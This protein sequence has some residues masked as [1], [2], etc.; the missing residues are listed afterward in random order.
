MVNQAYNDTLRSTKVS[1]GGMFSFARMKPLHAVVGIVTVF[2]LWSAV[3]MGWYVCGVNSL[4]SINAEATDAVAGE[5]S[6]VLG[7]ADTQAP[8]VAGYDRAG[9]A[10]EI[11]VMLMIAFTLG[12]L[13]GR[14]LGIAGSAQM[15]SMLETKIAPLHER[16]SAPV[17]I[18]ELTKHAPRP[19]MQANPRLPVSTLTP[20]PIIHLPSA[21]SRPPIIQ[22][23]P[24]AKPALETPAQKNMERPKI[25]FNTSW[26]NPVRDKP[27][28]S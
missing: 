2:L 16:I 17:H 23:K 9:A 15:P 26:S 25:R 11:F 21:A 7:L 28:T 24:P 3:S 14:V 10:G 5:G 12:A 22:I 4:C 20:A 27:P 18:S 8:L 1:V 6:E 13:L 19:P